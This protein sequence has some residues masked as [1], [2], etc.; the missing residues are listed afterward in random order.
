[1]HCIVFEIIIVFFVLISKLSKLIIV[2]NFECQ[3]LR[4]F[5]DNRVK[6]VNPR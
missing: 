6:L 3:E 1:M 2:N 4:T 5:D